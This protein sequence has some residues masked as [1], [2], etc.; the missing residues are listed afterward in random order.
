VPEGREHDVRNTRRRRTE[1]SGQAGGGRS[2]GTADR[3]EKSHKLV[4]AAPDRP[5]SLDALR[6]IFL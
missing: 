3:P 2:R 5:E 1:G 6:D 4:V